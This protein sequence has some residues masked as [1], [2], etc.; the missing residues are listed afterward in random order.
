MRVEKIYLINLEEMESLDQSNQQLARETLKLPMYKRKRDNDFDSGRI[1][2]LSN[3]LNTASTDL[4][5]N[6]LLNEFLS[7]GYGTQ[8][9]QAWSFYSQSSDH[10]KLANSTS[11]LASLIVACNDFSDGISQGSRICRE[12]IDSHLKVVYR[13]LFLLRPGV[14]VPAMKLI[15]NI[16]RFNGGSLINDL[17]SG[18]DFGLKVIPK[19]LSTE[20]L[21]F[22]FIEFLFSLLTIGSSIIKKDIIS[23]K[24][25]ISS[26][27]KGL[28]MDSEVLLLEMIDIFRN[29]IC[30][31][32]S[33]LKSSKLSFFNDWVLGNLLKL[34][35][36]KDLVPQA[37][38]DFLLLLSTDSMNGIKFLESGWYPA[39]LNEENQSEPLKV[40]ERTEKLLQPIY[41]KSLLSFLHIL[42]PWEDILQQKLVLSI[43]LFSPELVSPYVCFLD[44][45]LSFD[46]KLTSFWVSYSTLMSK[47]VSLPIPTRMPTSIVTPPDFRIV[48]DS[49]LPANISK[50]SLSK[51]LKDNLLVRYLSTEIIICGL[52]K[53]C[54]IKI[55]YE[56]QKW[57]EVPLRDEFLKRLPDIQTLTS[58]LQN[59]KKSSEFLR[60]TM[61]MAITL[62]SKT[63]PDILSGQ[64][65]SKS[66]EITKWE[67][68]SGIN[69]L[70]LHNALELETISGSSGKWWNKNTSTNM[71][72]FTTVLRL[73]SLNVSLKIQIAR[74][75]HKLL[76][77][78]L[79]FQD[80]TL[81]S[82]IEILLNSLYQNLPT[83]EV[84]QIKLWTLFDE[85]I[86]RVMR[87]P[88]KYIDC[89]SNICGNGSFQ[90]RS[91]PFIIAL[92][93]QWEYVDKTTSYKNLE[94]WVSSYVRDSCICG[95]NWQVANEL[96]NKLESYKPFKGEEIP[97]EGWF[98]CKK[99]SLFGKL[100][101]Q[102]RDLKTVEIKSLSELEAAK[103]R[104]MHSKDNKTRALLF[105]ISSPWI[106]NMLDCKYFMSLA[107]NILIFDEYIDCIQNHLQTNNDI[108]SLKNFLKS[109]TD[110]TIRKG[111]LLL[112]DSSDII[113]LIISQSN[114]ASFVATALDVLNSKNHTLDIDQYILLA[115]P[116]ASYDE[117]LSKNI[118][119]CEVFSEELADIFFKN[120]L[121]SSF[122]SIVEKAS[123]IKPEWKEIVTELE[124]HTLMRFASVVLKLKFFS[125]QT[126]LVTRA[127]SY[128]LDNLNDGKSLE[129][130]GES[131]GILERPDINKI[132][133]FI[134]SANYPMANSSYL[135]N[136]TGII[137]V[138]TKVDSSDIKKYT[139]RRILWLT[140]Y[141]SERM[142]ITDK[143]KGFLL[144]FGKKNMTIVIKLSILNIF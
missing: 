88:Y 27:I 126:N 129:F 72:L 51:C 96:A 50:S 36:R 9:L 23:H 47:I 92:L 14:S 22:N 105:D 45:H 17:Y 73:A 130:L 33:F 135:V 24:K 54:Q 30:M 85:S 8:V 127:I 55:Y 107:E 142:T 37:L 131:I 63:F 71:S 75:L 3:I 4:T 132:T 137:L 116:E 125:D 29:K 111:S 90:A 98:D 141:F 124:G 48:I 64:P 144:D 114:N 74:L 28:N 86:S 93:E 41:N 102:A 118:Q 100:F 42:K 128:A 68:I 21:R 133:K 97:L 83:N 16:A 82:P 91:S 1:E 20:G 2:D 59:V 53:Y 52:K 62:Y 79:A 139:Q 121:R 40:N 94:N 65:I 117:N 112:L 138:T 81:T 15:T 58:S 78:T 32:K 67:N 140:K 115:K 10:S 136:L 39:K 123:Y 110:L 120:R 12:I 89:Y 60:A 19:L 77:P 13:C 134:E 109:R 38:Y 108:T 26:W 31:D 57:D 69:L 18:F 70:N 49:V 76:T 34:F 6:H 56:K 113:S 119:I 46:P 103:F 25:I 66:L 106:N 122:V 5:K 104:I 7:H 101:C 84:E 87:S 80:K 44:E 43:L 143:E 95:E 61:Y 99:S 35:H 11:I